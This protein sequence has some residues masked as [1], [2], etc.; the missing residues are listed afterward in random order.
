MMSIVEFGRKLRARETSAAAMT[1]ECLRRIEQ[2]QRTPQRVHPRDG[3]RGAGGRRGK[4]TRSWPPAPIAGR[5]TASLFQIKDLVDVRGTATTAASRVREGH[6]AERDAPIVANLRQAGAV[7]VGKTNL[8][9]F[10]FGT[11]NEDSAFGP[12]AQSVRSDAI[13]W[14]IERRIGREPCRR[15]GPRD[16]RHRHRGLRSDSGSRVRDGRTEALVRRNIERGRGPV[17]PHARSRRPARQHGDR[18]M[19]SVPRLAGSQGGSTP[20]RLARRQPPPRRR[21]PVL[22]RSAR[23]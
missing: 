13:P 20:D 18:R 1:D 15:H 8:H 4:P 7:I 2:R 17:I 12:G 19:V 16:R 6:R 21:P 14:R 10:A 9:E 5:F 23:R 22:L 11:T 3:R